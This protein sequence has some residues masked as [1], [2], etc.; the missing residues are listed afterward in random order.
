MELDRMIWT[1][2]TTF[3]IVLLILTCGSASASLNATDEATLGTHAQH[4][5]SHV[6]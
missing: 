4:P 2:R 1:S 3:T 5:A 6:G